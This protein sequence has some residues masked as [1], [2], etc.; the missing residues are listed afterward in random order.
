MYQGLKGA[1]EIKEK[2]EMLHNLLF[3]HILTTYSH[4]PNKQTSTIEALII[5]QGR[6]IEQ[7]GKINEI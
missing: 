4:F 5:E 3:G 7:G 1:E 6:I 2:R